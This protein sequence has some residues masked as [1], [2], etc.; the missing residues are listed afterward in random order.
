MKIHKTRLGGI[1]FANLPKG[2]MQNISVN[3]LRE[4]ANH[5]SVSDEEIVFKTEE[6]SV[7]FDVVYP[8]GRYC[9]TCGERLPDAGSTAEHEAE[10]AKA[11][12]EHCE[13]HGKKMVTEQKWPHGY[14]HQPRAYTCAAKDTELNK[15]LI[16]AER[17]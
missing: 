12:R 13:A 3:T 8:P 1:R 7:A 9:L 14:R 2:G 11:C 10:N 4:L 16:A 17:G 15:K 6:G 5:V